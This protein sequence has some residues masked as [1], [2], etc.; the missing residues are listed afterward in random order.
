MVISIASDN[1]AYLTILSSRIHVIWSLAAGGTLEDRPRYN[2]SRC[3]ETFPFPALEEGELKSRLRD[4]G[5]RLDAH[6]KR[7]Q[8]LHPALTLTGLYKALTT[9]R[10]GQ[11][12]SA[13]EKRGLI[14]P[15][16]PPPS[17]KPTKNAPTKSKVSSR[18]CAG[19]DC[20]ESSGGRR[21]PCRIGILPM[22][23][24]L[25]SESGEGCPAL[26]RRAR[27]GHG[28][29][30][31]ATMSRL[32]PRSPVPAGRAPSSGPRSRRGCGLWH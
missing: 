18:P 15:P 27:R 2:K 21:D 3:F 24:P 31:R 5:E 17:A 4:L 7:Q 20:C 14:R 16:S 6:R 13:K 9:L 10:R 22:P 11:A 12:L 1:S 25:T 32:T 26:P 30:A 19:W 8:A 28:L 23:F 29:E